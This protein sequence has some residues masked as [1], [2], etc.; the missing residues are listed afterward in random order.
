MIFLLFLLA[1]CSISLRSSLSGV[2]VEAWVLLP[3]SFRFEFGCV[4][5]ESVLQVL[6]LAV[7]SIVYGFLVL[8]VMAIFMV[9]V[10]WFFVGELTCWLEIRTLSAVRKLCLLVVL[11]WRV[12]LVQAMANLFLLVTNN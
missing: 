5:F 10:G 8:V 2:P 12:V 11:G 9:P 3:P 4:Y 1:A 6:L 7:A